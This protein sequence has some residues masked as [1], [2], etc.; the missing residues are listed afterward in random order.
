MGGAKG[1]VE[2][3]RAPAQLQDP[4]TKQFLAA[5]HG[6]HALRRRQLDGREA[7]RPKQERRH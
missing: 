2:P 1:L 5:H 4:P 3:N 6:A 7:R